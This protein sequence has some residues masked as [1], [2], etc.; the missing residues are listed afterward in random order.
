MFANTHYQT[1]T[2]NRREEALS[3]AKCRE[4]GK[5]IG[6]EAA[7]CP[8]CGAPS[9]TPAR[10]PASRAIWYILVGIVVIIILGN[11]LNGGHDSQQDTAASAARANADTAFA[12]HSA[13]AAS[14]TGNWRTTR[15]DYPYCTTV[16]QFDEVVK[17]FAD[18][19]KEAV[20]QMLTSRECGTLKGGV[21][22]EIVDTTL[23]SG[24]VR[25]RP[26]GSRLSVWT[27]TEAVR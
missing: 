24:A 13:D 11:A 2:L 6:T 3:L 9:P 1:H 12:A 20:T 23:L 10:P 26:R 16:D 14:Q 21:T 4:C 15:A 8:N 7:S 19:D 18:K 27:N 25:I 22:V 17:Y 5:R